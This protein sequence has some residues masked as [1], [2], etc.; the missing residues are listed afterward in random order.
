V[1][2]WV[3]SLASTWPGAFA[4]TLL[5]EVPVWVFALGPR[6]GSWR[7]R[8]AAGAAASTVTHPLLWLVAPLIVS[9]SF[10]CGDQLDPN[11]L[12]ACF[13]RWIHALEALI[14][15][16]EAALVTV[17]LP[18]SLRRALLASLLANGASY[19]FGLLLR[20]AN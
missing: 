11:G 17:V 20:A 1:L 7:M 3:A 2:S 9:V 12:A 10:A 14:V 16:V 15:L 19:G 18:A 6:A 8:A 4:L 13:G 5:L